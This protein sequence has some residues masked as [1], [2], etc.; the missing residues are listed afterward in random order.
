ML[1]KS[2]LELVPFRVIRWIV[3]RACEVRCRGVDVVWWSMFERG[4][5]ANGL[6]VV[7]AEII[8]EQKSCENTEYAEEVKSGFPVSP[9]EEDCPDNFWGNSGQDGRTHANRHAS[10]PAQRQWLSRLKPQLLQIPPSLSS[11]SPPL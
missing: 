8:E 9:W 4:P 6:N 7:P 2:L 11:N 1:G 3:R 5:V 10:I